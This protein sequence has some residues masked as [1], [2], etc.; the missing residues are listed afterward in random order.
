V[1]LIRSAIFTGLWAMNVA[2]VLYYAKTNAEMGREPLDGID[3]ASFRAG[4]DWYPSQGFGICTCFDP[5]AESADAFST[6]IQRL[7]GCSV[8]R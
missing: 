5:P 3:A 8:S 6:R 1:G 4:A 2:H 7:G